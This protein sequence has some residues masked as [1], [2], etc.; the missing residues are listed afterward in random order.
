MPSVHRTRLKYVQTVTLNTG[1]TPSLFGSERSFRLNS[2]F[3]PDVAVG[4]HQPYGFDQMAAFYNKYLVT[5]ALVELTLTNPSADGL[6]FACQVRSPSGA[7]GVSGNDVDSVAERQG[8]MVKYINDSGAQVYTLK[9]D[10]PNHEI[11]GLSPAQYAGQIDQ[12]GALVSANPNLMNNIVFAIS[13]QANSN[14]ESLIVMV[15][16]SYDVTY[17]DRLQYL[18][19]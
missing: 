3:D 4:G 8:A 6:I 2:I 12:T 18:A 7:F 14:N 5:R 19:S 11:M 13:N 16:I 17:S 1:T 15:R 9:F 10:L